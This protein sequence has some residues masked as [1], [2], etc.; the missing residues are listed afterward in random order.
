MIKAIKIDVER[1]MLYEV[2]LEPSLDAIKGQLDCHLIDVIR[3][4]FK[5]RSVIYIDDEGL[6]VQEPIGY[7]SVKGAYGKFA[8]HG[9]VVGTDSEG[10][11]L[12]TKISI[13][14][15]TER[16]RFHGNDNTEMPTLIFENYG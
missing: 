13:E 10:N 5:D 7:F 14:E 8:G 3:L 15:L 1:K 9:L 2:H 12:D 16:I 6:Y 11:D 4:N